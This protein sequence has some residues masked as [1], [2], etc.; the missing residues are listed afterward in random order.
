MG[1]VGGHRNFGFG[2]KMAWAGKQ[3]LRE[4]YGD[5][6]HRSVAAHAERWARFVGWARDNCAIRDAR[7]VNNRCAPGRAKRR[8]VVLGSREARLFTRRASARQRENKARIR[9][10]RRAVCGSA[11]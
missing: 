4:R 10:R 5:G 6:H 11:A 8:R 3:A 9:T 2:K 7:Q 1:K